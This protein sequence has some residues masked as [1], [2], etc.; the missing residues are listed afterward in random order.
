[1][2]LASGNIAT[3]YAEATVWQEDFDPV[4]LG[5]TFEFQSL[6]LGD[7]R[8]PAASTGRRSIA[9]SSSSPTT[10]T[11]EPVSFYVAGIYAVPTS[12]EGDDQLRLR[13]RDAST[14]TPRR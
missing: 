12:A 8:S 3:D 14:F 13:R 10:S 1:M 4:I 5:S 6:P 7:F 11:A 9:P 2:R